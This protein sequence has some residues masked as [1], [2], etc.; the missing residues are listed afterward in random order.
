MTKRKRG[1]GVGQ[2]S[3]LQI[4]GGGEGSDGTD[5]VANI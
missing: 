1:G 2:V 3:R 5:H 4:G